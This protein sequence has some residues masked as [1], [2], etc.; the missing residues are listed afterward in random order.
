[1]LLILLYY[2]PA[3]GLIFDTLNV[4]YRTVRSGKIYCSPELSLD[5]IGA[6]FFMYYCEVCIYDNIARRF[7][8]AP[9]HELYWLRPC[10]CKLI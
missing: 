5:N 6:F 8:Q 10:F 4:K 2:L 7:P 1:M 9:Q 3:N